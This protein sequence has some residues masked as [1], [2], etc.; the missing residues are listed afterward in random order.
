MFCVWG[1]DG[2]GNLHPP[3]KTEGKEGVLKWAE[4]GFE[5]EGAVGLFKRVS[6]AVFQRSRR[7]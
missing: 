3:H 2:A 5:C 4:M 7:C 1:G 6:Y